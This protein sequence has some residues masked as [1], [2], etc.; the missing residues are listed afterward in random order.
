[1]YFTV[2]SISAIHRWDPRK[3]VLLW[4]ICCFTL[5]PLWFAVQQPEEPPCPADSCCNTTIMGLPLVYCRDTSG[6]YSLSKNHLPQILNVS[7]TRPP[8]P[9]EQLHKTFGKSSETFTL[10]ILDLNVLGLRFESE[11]VT[12]RMDG[13]KRLLEKGLYD[14]VLI[15]EAW[16]N[17]DYRWP[18]IM[19]TCDWSGSILQ[20]PCISVS[21]CYQIWNIRLHFVKYFQL[22][23]FSLLGISKKL[24]FRKHSLSTDIYCILSRLINGCKN[25]IH[26]HSLCACIKIDWLSLF[27]Q[28]A[29]CV[30]LWLSIKLTANFFLS[31]AMVLWYS[32]GY[33]MWRFDWKSPFCLQMANHQRRDSAVY[34]KNSLVL[35]HRHCEGT[36]RS[37]R[38]FCCYA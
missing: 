17:K 33:S 32:A 22:L 37:E 4:F 25:L 6:S 3:M 18:N 14:I 9:T 5:L 21:L 29:Q 23:C 38:S 1:M 15:Q 28:E 8:L 36:R 27:L 16:Y 31:T 26:M 12:T 34:R 2:F 10:R 7:N 19:H 30:P 24:S 13:I 35:Q 20:D 11:T